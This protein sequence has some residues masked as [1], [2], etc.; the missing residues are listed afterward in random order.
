VRERGAV[1]ICCFC[2][3]PLDLCGA[4]LGFDGTLVFA[5]HQLAFEKYVIAG[6]Y[7][8]GVLGYGARVS[9][10]IVPLRFFLPLLLCILITL[11]GGDGEFRYASAV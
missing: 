1:W 10:A 6:L 5:I 9:N 3:R 7:P 4:T 8:G 11:R 2:Q